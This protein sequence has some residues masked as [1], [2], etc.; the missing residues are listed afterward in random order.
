M[1]QVNIMDGAFLPFG[2]LRLHGT[3]HPKHFE[4]VQGEN[5]N[6]TVFVTDTYLNRDVVAKRRIAWLLEPPG[7]RQMNYDYVLAHPDKFEYI[8]TYVE[9]MHQALPEKCLYYSMGYTMLT[10]EQVESKPDKYEQNI[11]FIL[12]AKQAATGHKFR[13]EINEAIHMAGLGEWVDVYGIDMYDG[14][15]EFTPKW[16]C[17]RD[18][19][20]TICVMGEKYNWCIDEKIIDCFLARTIPIFWGYP[21]IGEKHGKYN[22]DGIIQFSTITELLDIIRRILKEGDAM[23]NDRRVQR[24]L[25][26]NYRL[27]TYNCKIADEEYIWQYH[28]LKVF[29]EEM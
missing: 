18:Y 4:W 8:L 22:T 14:L 25:Q 7:F 16:E 15:D 2:N 21:D 29:D 1:K 10:E 26:H 9:Y 6:A 13:H 19:K 5:A 20:F 3:D 12:S 28:R 23:Y 11:S 17:L 27:A 24:A